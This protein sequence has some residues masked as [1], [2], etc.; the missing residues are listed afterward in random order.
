MRQLLLNSALVAPLLM[1]MAVLGMEN[2]QDDIRLPGREVNSIEASMLKGGACG[3]YESDDC[4]AC[5]G[6]RAGLKSGGTKSSSTGGG[7]A[8]SCSSNTATNVCSGG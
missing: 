8:S 1:G 5:S 6:K 4:L 3:G 7:C 2:S